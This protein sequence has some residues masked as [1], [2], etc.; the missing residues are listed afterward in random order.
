[1][2][3]T[4]GDNPDINGDD[5]TGTP[6]TY[7]CAQGYLV[8]DFDPAA[9]CPGPCC[10][11][12]CTDATANNYD[13]AATCDDGSCTYD[14]C[15]LVLAVD[16]IADPCEEDL[17]LTFTCSTV[18]PTTA[19]ITWEY[20]DGTASAWVFAFFDQL[21]P[22]TTGDTSTLI[23]AFLILGGETDYRAVVDMYFASVPDCQQIATL[24]Y[25][26]PPTGCMDPSATNYDPAAICDD[27]CIYPVLGCTDPTATNFNYNCALLPVI[28][29][30]D[31]TCC[32]T[33]VPDC[34]TN[35][36]GPYSNYNSSAE[37][38]CDGTWVNDPAGYTPLGTSENCC[39]DC[40]LGC[41]DPLASNYDPAATCDDGSCLYCID[42][43]T[44]H[45]NMPGTYNNSLGGTGSPMN[46]V[47]ALNYD[48]TATC[49]DGTCCYEG[50]MD[51]TASNYDANY[52]AD[53]AGNPS[54][55][56]T[57]CCVYPPSG[58]M[59]N[60]PV[61]N[62]G[63]ALN[64][65]ASATVD[66][67]SCLYCGSFTSSSYSGTAYVLDNVL[68]DTT[69]IWLNALNSITNASLGAATD[70]S[71]NIQI[72]EAHPS[73]TIIYINI[74]DNAGVTV[75]SSSGPPTSG[76]TYTFP[77]LGYGD[78]TAILSFDS[79]PVFNTPGDCDSTFSFTVMTLDCTDP[80]ALNTTSIPL[81]YVIANTALCY[82]PGYC[83]C[84]SFITSLPGP[85]CSGYSI[86]NA[87]ITC[88]P[89]TDIS[90][91][92]L[93]NSGA[94]I[95]SGT[96]PGVVNSSVVNLQITTA[97]TYTFEYTEDSTPFGACPLNTNTVIVTST[98]IC[99]CT[100]PTMSN[101]DPAATLDCN[102]DPVGTEAT[103]WNDDPCCLECDYG[104]TDPAALNYDPLATC[105]DGTCI[106]PGDGCCD[107]LATN[108]NSYATNCVPEMCEYC[109]D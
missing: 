8:S 85:T 66:D 1:M 34:A 73:A 86:I 44:D 24:N 4:A 16:S 78:Y 109:N 64:Y 55:I 47:A 31:D 68:A 38:D 2:D 70:G 74:F 61:T 58:C 89:A 81:Q 90:W 39:I 6:C 88:S 62:G 49:D 99:G 84:T 26:F 72:V 10:I 42:G 43:C 97:G 23:N 35:A 15:S 45:G 18:N 103:G 65:D 95:L 37:C 41:T 104:C 12:G 77:G 82:Y 25:T 105:D 27:A 71:A 69:T 52:C 36:N 102:G 14:C 7:P 107:P 83:A 48:P 19:D 54:N 67:G 87:N 106:M 40:L 100:D 93:D 56:D 57:S 75:G 101:Y 17:E 29:T 30:L 22:A 53:C 5:S 33:C 3:N 28:A 98:D 76:T 108:F 92:L 63:V 60:D 80:A 32:F 51:P 9:L 91:Q 79:V 50:C 20:W 21:I 13:A 11:N 59:D 96:D 94:I 46:P